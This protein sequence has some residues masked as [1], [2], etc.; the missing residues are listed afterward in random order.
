[1]QQ[2]TREQALAGLNTPFYG[3]PV[4]DDSALSLNEVGQWGNWFVA[5]KLVGGG[6]MKSASGLL[7]PNWLGEG[8]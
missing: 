4:G 8:T 7:P 2:L 1:M 3:S 5:P 6:N